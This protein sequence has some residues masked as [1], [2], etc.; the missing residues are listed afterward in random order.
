MKF[1]LVRETDHINP[2]RGAYCI[3][4]HYI[5][6]TESVSAALVCRCNMFDAIDN[7]FWAAIQI[8]ELFI[9]HFVSRIVY[10]ND[11]SFN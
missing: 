1:A 3:I 9:E 10:R 6:P 7:S 8:A 2:V 5:R 4:Q 11:I